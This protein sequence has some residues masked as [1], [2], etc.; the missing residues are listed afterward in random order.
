MAM[1]ES[2]LSLAKPKSGE[3]GRTKPS[4]VPPPPPPPSRHGPSRTPLGVPVPPPRA[5]FDYLPSIDGLRAIAIA[6]VVLYHADVPW[7]PGGFIGVEVFLVISGFLIT[8][9]LGREFRRY[10]TI[11]ITDFW[12]RRAR[13]LLPAMWTVIFCVTLFAAYALPDELASLRGDAIAALGYAANWVLIFDHRS[14]FEQAGRP[15]LL[16][17]FWSLAIE[18][19]FYL[20]WPAMFS[21]VFARIQRRNAVAVLVCAASCSA[22]WMAALFHPDLDPSRLYFGTDTR[23]SGLLLGAALA[24]AM[25]SAGLAAPPRPASPV[26]EAFGL[27]S[28]VGL[29]AICFTL[30]E[31]DPPLYLGG[32]FGIAVLTT[33][34]IAAAVRQSS[35]IVG[36]LLRFE[37]MRWLGVRSYSLYLWHFP[38]FMVTR[39]E[40]DLQLTGWP[41]LAL[42]IV[43]A[44]VCAELSYR[45]I[46]SPVRDGALT[47]LWAYLTRDH[48]PLRWVLVGAWTLSI[49]ALCVEV[50]SAK[51][52]HHDPRPEEMWVAKPKNEPPPPAALPA[53]ALP[54]AA[55]SKPARRSAA[56]QKADELAALTAAPAAQA[57]TAPLVAAVSAPPA[58]AVAPVAAVAANPNAAARSKKVLAIGDS[59]MLGA[60]RHLRVPGEQVTIDAAVGRQASATVALLEQLR[61]AGGLPELVV[62]HI[63][64]NGTL[65]DHQLDQMMRLLAGV[66]E[67][68]FVNTK[69][70]RRWQ[71]PNNLVLSEGV[72]RH[73]KRARLVDW[74][75]FSQDHPEWF[76]ADGYHL[77]P[78][79]AAAYAALLRPYY[80]GK[81]AEPAL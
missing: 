43:L 29:I 67:V 78:E 46:E 30:D 35:P 8:S 79:G 41:S 81:R 50:G 55:P 65:R 47:R 28:L 73:H 14:Y 52:P 40:L 4:R 2:K 24:L 53:P 58:N 54:A 80:S 49:A 44:L 32:F 45:Y 33:L 36:R 11:D 74:L 16:K 37:P 72:R 22:A 51:N 23:A 71:D 68:V 6:A 69:V 57:V 13:R 5:A 39:P 20:V 1:G 76:R 48:G 21:L 9:L 26:L 38:V 19:Q 62:I 59:V 31:Y 77:Q 15:S 17:H 18:Q 64:N 10:G 42:R 34:V 75:A 56:R 3:L 63:G 61:A 7:M 27:A 60:A 25:P 70:P 12:A 66:P